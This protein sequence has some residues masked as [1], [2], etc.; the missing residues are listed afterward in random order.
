M[1]EHLIRNVVLDL[2]RYDLYLV[3]EVN[4]CFQFVVGWCLCLGLE[5]ELVYLVVLLEVVN[6]K[7][8]RVDFDFRNL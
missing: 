1:L 7:L 6:W 3:V 4:L 5:L 2:I 8:L